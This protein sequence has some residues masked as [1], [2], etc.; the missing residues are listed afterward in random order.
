MLSIFNLVLLS[1]RNSPKCFKKGNDKTI[2]FMF[3]KSYTG[4]R[5]E[6]DIDPGKVQEHDDVL[7]W[8]GMAIWE[9]G[10]KD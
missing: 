8:Y 5:I 2:A 4:N 3:L 1:K 6:R 10:V 7:W 9:V